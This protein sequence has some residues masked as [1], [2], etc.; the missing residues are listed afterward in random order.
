M[1]VQWYINAL[2]VDRSRSD[3]SKRLSSLWPLII[4]YTC[5]L[6]TTT[7]EHLGTMGMNHKESFVDFCFSTASK[8]NI[9][10]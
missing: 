2:L 4:A 8:S 10:K 7:D 1:D 6:T 3:R 9:S 5:I